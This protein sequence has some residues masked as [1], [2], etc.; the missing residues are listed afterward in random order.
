MDGSLVGELA[1]IGRNAVAVLLVNLE[2]MVR[3]PSVGFVASTIPLMVILGM[4]IYKVSISGQWRRGRRYLEEG[5]I[6]VVVVVVIVVIVVHVK[7]V[8]QK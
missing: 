6:V 5:V 4:S 8:L 2:D 7:L 1:N 3:I